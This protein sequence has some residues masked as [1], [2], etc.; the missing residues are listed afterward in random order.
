VWEIQIL[1]EIKLIRDNAR[2]VWETNL[3]QVLK[4]RRD[5]VFKST[6][7]T[8]TVEITRRKFKD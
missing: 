8:Q 7:E 6:S 3:F 5:N 1:E 4:I 2:G